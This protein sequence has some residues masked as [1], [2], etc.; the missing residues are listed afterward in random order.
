VQHARAILLTGHA[1]AS[2][3]LNSNRSRETG[4]GSKIP[5]FLIAGK[6]IAINFVARKPRALPPASAPEILGVDVIE[7]SQRSVGSH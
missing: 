3:G 7:A 4:A 2:N 6:T 1:R 5:D